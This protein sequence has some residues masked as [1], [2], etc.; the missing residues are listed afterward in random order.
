MDLGKG[1]DWSRLRDTPPLRQA[2]QESEQL[3][4]GNETG[5]GA[6]VCVRERGPE[7]GC[8]MKISAV[9]V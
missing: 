5:E 9:C 3:K 1:R 2:A 7:P 4:P 6:K 8:F